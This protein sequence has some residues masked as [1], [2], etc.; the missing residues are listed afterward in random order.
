[1]VGNIGIAHRNDAFVLVRRQIKLERRNLEIVGVQQSQ[2]AFGP[3]LDQLDVLVGRARILVRYD[4]DVSARRFRRHFDNM[5][6]GD[7]VAGR[8]DKAGAHADRIE[9][10]AAITA[11][12]DQ[13]T[14]HRLLGGLEGLGRIDR[15][16]VGIDHIA[17]RLIRVG[18]VGRCPMGQADKAH[19]GQAQ[20]Q[21]GSTK[22]CALKDLQTSARLQRQLNYPIC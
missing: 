8:H 4:I 16:Q 22:P 19:R 3:R 5:V 10:H 20:N 13:D 2:V 21:N 18:I 15:L 11:I 12:N 17:D 14:H 9:R 1:M 6:I 7:D